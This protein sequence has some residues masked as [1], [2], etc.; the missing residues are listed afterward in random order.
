MRFKTMTTTLAL[1]LMVVAGFVPPTPA[2]S[3]GAASVS[4]SSERS[5]QLRVTKNCSAYTGLAGSYCTITSSNLKEIG[6]GSTLYTD[7]AY[8]ILPVPLLDSDV[9]LYVGTGDWAVGHC[10]LDGMTNLGLCTFSDGSGP[11][12]GFQARVDV[13]SPDGVNYFWDGTY[14]FSSELSDRR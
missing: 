7:L 11:L 5:G 13:S 3:T 6:V 1:A 4:A 12:R 8:G 14:S 2:L 9:V 10:T